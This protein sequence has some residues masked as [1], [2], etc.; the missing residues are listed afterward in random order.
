MSDSLVPAGS[1]AMANAPSAGV[2]HEYALSSDLARLSLPAEY[3]DSYRN[4]AWTNSI[5]FLFLVIGLVGLKAPRVI[6]K[7]LIEVTESAPVIFTPPEDQPK[8][9]PEVQ[10]DEP[11]PQDAPVETPQV[12]TVAAP[13]DATVAFAVPVQG[14]VALA[15]E[16]RFAS[17]PPPVTQAPAG[18]TKFN[19]N[20]NDGG[21]YPGPKYPTLAEAH[22]Y[23]GTVTL[24]ILVD[25]FGK[26]TSVKVRKTSGYSILDDA[27]LKVVKDSWR[28]PPTGAPRDLL[29]DCIYQLQ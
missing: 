21:R 7:P 1:S 5:C 15:K 16:V 10:P 25:E 29:W 22:Q 28:F 14:A 17:P 27:A 19:P 24:E 8:P 26:I 12:V 23:Q 6:H 11:A 2:S 20:A 13:A 18:P 9:E 3:V 4:L